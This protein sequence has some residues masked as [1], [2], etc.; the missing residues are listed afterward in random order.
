MPAT[1]HRVTCVEF[2]YVTDMPVG[3]RTKPLTPLGDT[4]RSQI[5]DTMMPSAAAVNRTTST[6]V[7]MIATTPVPG[8]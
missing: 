6:I 1:R 5:I 2:G 7:T 4:R 3:A 8:K